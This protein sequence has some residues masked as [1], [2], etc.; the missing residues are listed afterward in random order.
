MLMMNRKGS[1]QKIS[2][3]SGMISFILAFILS[4]VTYVRSESM[5]S[6]GPIYASLMATIFFF[7]CIGI[8]LTIMGKADIPSFKF[9]KSE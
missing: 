8:V 3:Y 7:V 9:E 6:N 4:I 1:L 5:A 2:F